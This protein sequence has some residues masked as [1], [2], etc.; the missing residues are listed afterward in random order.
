[1][2]DI[3]TLDIDTPDGELVGQP[4]NIYKVIVNCNQTRGIMV[5]QYS[6]R[7]LT[8]EGYNRVRSTRDI[9]SGDVIY[10]GGILEIE[11]EPQ[12]NKHGRIA[13]RHIDPLPLKI[14]AIYPA[15]LF[16]QNT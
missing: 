9:A 2:T 11:V 15:G 4:K 10:K 5:G 6:E 3:E 13:I 8:T 12:W 14:I 1:M 16:E 7:T